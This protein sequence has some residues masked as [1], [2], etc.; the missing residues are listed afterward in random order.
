MTSR[1][2]PFATGRPPE[3]SIMFVPQEVSACIASMVCLLSSDEAMPRKED[4]STRESA[5]LNSAPTLTDNVATS[6]KRT[7][8]TSSSKTSRQASTSRGAACKPFWNKHSE[9]WSR[10][11]WSCTRTGLQDLDTT[12]W[13]SSSQKLALD[14]WFTVKMK[15]QVT[16]TTSQTTSSPSQRSSLLPITDVVLLQIEREERKKKEQA[17][18]AKQKREEKKA[19]EQAAKRR[20]VEVEM[21]QEEEPEKKKQ[22]KKVYENPM[23][24]R[25]IKILPNE[26]QEKGLKNWFGAVRFCYNQLVAKYRNVGQGGV[27]KD[28]LRKVIKEAEAE[29]KWLA[30]IPYDVKDVA[31]SDFANAR[32]AH[33]A[34]L[35]KKQAND[36]TA[37]HDAKFKFRSK[38]DRQQSFEVRARDMVR[39]SGEYAFINI[40][41]LQATEDFPSKEVEAAVRFIRD[42]LGHYYLALPRQVAKRSESQAPAKRESVVALD[43][44]VRSFQT[45]YDLTNLATEWGKDDMKRLFT[46]CRFADKIQSAWQSKKGAKRRSTK[47]AWHRALFRIKNKVKELHRK[48]ATWLCENYKVIL[49]PKFETSRMVRRANRKIRSKTAR[50]MLTWSHFAFRELLKAKAELFPWVKVVECDEA[51][52]SK[53]CGNCGEL[54]HTLGGAKTFKCKHCNYVADRDISAARNILLRYLSLKCKGEEGRMSQDTGFAT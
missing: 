9:A 31:V 21:P 40:K 13:S 18:K 36:P 43:P 28:V 46:L 37:R 51:Y 54:H 53:T 11:L 20:K 8:G 25:R 39:Q 44:G 4:T 12:S 6:R 30:D 41:K 2:A 33:F 34:K 45:T 17:E 22:E 5:V 42:R 7:R 26:E 23:R 47:L 50:G 3:G 27:T 24:A 35:K 16:S 49:I 15:A 38:K 32:K 48:M 14:S 10:R 29:N 1:P 19:A 52:T